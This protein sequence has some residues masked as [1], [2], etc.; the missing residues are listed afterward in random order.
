V[1]DEENRE[2]AIYSEPVSR[3][4]DLILIQNSRYRLGS[5]QRRARLITPSQ[6]MARAMKAT[7]DR[8]VR[9]F[10]MFFISN[11]ETARPVW[12]GLA[13]SLTSQDSVAQ[14]ERAREARIVQVTL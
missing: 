4:V 13:V 8:N 6:G 7:L 10:Q 3:P 14:K 11:V 1:P 9:D 2:P 12:N 5:L